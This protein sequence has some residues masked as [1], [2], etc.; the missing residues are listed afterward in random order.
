MSTITCKLFGVPQILKDGQPVFLPYSKINALLYYV[1]VSKVVSREE[2]AGLLW[3]DE[4]DETARR[5]LRNAIY[6]AKKA[7]GTNLILSP[8]KS[9]LM[10]NE[11]LDLT[12]DVDQFLQAPQE[13]LRLYTGE[14][15]QGFFLKGAETY[16]YWIVKMRNYFKEK[17]FSECYQKVADD[18]DARRYD[19]VETHIRYLMELDEYDERAFRLLLRFYQ[20]TG[21]NGKVIESYYEFA[22]LLRRELGVAPDQTTKEIYE[23]ALEEM[24]FE[25]GRSASNDESFFF[26]R[27]QEIAALDKAL[28]EFKENPA[29]GRSILICGEPG[30]GRSTM[31]RRALDG[32]EEHFYILQTQ[33]LSIGQDF[34]LRPW[35]QIAREITHLLQEEPCIPPL[36]WNDLM[37]RVFPDFQEH[38]PS[39]EFL[40][41]P[42]RVSIG[43]LAHVMVE[44]IHTLSA[45]K[46]VILVVE[47][48]QWL[49]PDSLRLLTTVMLELSPSQAILLAT[50]TLARNRPL[51]DALSAL[52]YHSPML[53]LTLRRFTVEACHSLI[54]KALPPSQAGNGELLE[55]IYN[56]T[57]GNP[58]LL[59]EYIAMLQRGESLDHSSPAIQSFLRTQLLGL[60]QEALELAE[61]L[62][63]FYDGA[64]L[65][66]AAQ[67]LGKNASDLL[68]PLEQLEN[69]GVFLKH[70]GSQEAIHFAHP[71]LREFIYHAQPV[72]QRAARHLAI[73]QLL[74]QQ[75][76]Q[77]R[78][79]NRV[80][81]LLIFH[82]SQ[83][84]Y[85]LEAM[86]YKIAN[87]NSRLNF[88]HEIFPV[89]SEEDVALQT[90]CEKFSYNLQKRNGA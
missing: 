74:E 56:E 32:A 28:K 57:E 14:F 16:E 73:G 72:S 70:T 77:N 63:C 83:A 81:P 55:Q 54:K 47:N 29:G 78:H 31:K 5:N 34:S 22:K 4:M 52:Q 17:F 64:P 69:R 25:T 38:L 2:L 68:A 58:F 6:Q 42:E 49:D 1:L 90:S 59:N 40:T 62:S 76:H 36:L 13:N 10:L 79:K 85:Q 86:K 60:S 3:P 51:D 43:Q 9:L 87:L 75:L 23:R 37:S 12:L 20:E 44:A 84:G 27:Y 66:S 50:C 46:R 18:L 8:K 26:G 88:S 65:S 45:R 30:S 33:G 7:L 89:L 80:Y 48:L 19:S 67:I 82:F 39:A 15:L 61:V 41:E 53:I 71:K 35:R 24:H 11:N 21:R